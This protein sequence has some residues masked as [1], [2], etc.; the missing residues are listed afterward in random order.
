MALRWG[1]GCCF[2][3]CCGPLAAAGKN[4][5]KGIHH[6]NGRRGRRDNPFVKS[7]IYSLKADRKEAEDEIFERVIRHAS[8]WN[9]QT[10]MTDAEYAAEQAEIEAQNAE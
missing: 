7:I 2:G 9:G 4:R 8:D 10:V 3:P 5:T 6:C 1:A